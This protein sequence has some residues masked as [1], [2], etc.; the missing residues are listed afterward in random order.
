VSSRSV[1]ALSCNK[2]DDS[3]WRYLPCNSVISLLLRA[4]VVQS[5]DLCMF[6]RQ[7]TVALLPKTVATRF[8]F[9]ITQQQTIFVENW[10][11]ICH[12]CVPFLLLCKSVRHSGRVCILICCG[13]GTAQTSKGKKP[14]SCC[15][16]G[17]GCRSQW[18][19]ST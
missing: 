7:M 13:F 5:L 12:E 11:S 2:F 16:T 1:K 10:P 4:N 15:S 9:H 6:S 18:S 17:A 3:S 14:T 19:L 8:K